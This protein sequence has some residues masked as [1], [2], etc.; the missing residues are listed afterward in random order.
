MKALRNSSYLALVA[1]MALGISSCKE[2]DDP[3][4]PSPDRKIA[5]EGTYPTFMR[6][7][8]VEPKTLPAE[9]YLGKCFDLVGHTAN[10]AGGFT[11]WSVLDE[12]RIASNDPWSPFGRAITPTLRV[13]RHTELSVQPEDRSFKRTYQS[14]VD[15][16]FSDSMVVAVG[17]GYEKVTCSYGNRRYSVGSLQRYVY[18]YTTGYKYLYERYEVADPMDYEFYLSKR[19]VRDLKVLSAAE[20]VE[21]YGTHV[22]TSYSTGAS[23]DLAVAANSSLF[24]ESEVMAIHGALWVGGMPLFPELQK[25]VSN[26]YS[27]LGVTYLQSGSKYEPNLSSVIDLDHTVGRYDQRLFQEQINANA[28]TTFLELEEGN[29]SIPSLISDIPL[30]VKYFSGIL[31]L[32]RPSELGST[33]YVL[34]N[35]ETYELIPYQSTCLNVMLPRYESQQAFV[36]IGA[37][38]YKIF[39]EEGRSMTRWYARMQKTGLW[40]FQSLKSSKYLCRDFVLRTEQE[41]TGNLRFWGLNPTVATGVK[42]RYSLANLLIRKS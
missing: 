5:S 24:T 34:S 23:Q 31:D 16:P 11:R 17:T 25:K 18:R 4:R 38:P 13:P 35:P 3:D 12:K 20:L 33:M 1:L 10:D 32:V 41:D 2:K 29:P 14:S 42:S 8:G 40:T 15:K 28:H 6:L 37:G 27:Q 9:R 26:N 7:H 21:K 39:E 22:V 30:K 19:F 36:Y